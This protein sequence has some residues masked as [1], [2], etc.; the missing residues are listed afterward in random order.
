MDGHRAGRQLEGDQEA[1]KR[2]AVN[3]GGVSGHFQI[4][5]AQCACVTSIGNEERGALLVSE[6]LVMCRGHVGCSSILT[7]E[8]HR[9][10]DNLLIVPIAF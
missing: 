5:A 9:P 7:Q 10:A 1:E 3:A 2:I 6:I 4:V 8:F